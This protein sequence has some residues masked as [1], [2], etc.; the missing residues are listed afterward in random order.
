ME[1]S[2][3]NVSGTYGRAYAAPAVNDIRHPAAFIRGYY[4]VAVNKITF[5][6]GRDVS[7]KRIAEVGA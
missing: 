3:H 2:A 4:F 5:I 1:L 7:E 6:A